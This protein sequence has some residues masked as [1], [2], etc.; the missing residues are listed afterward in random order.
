MQPPVVAPV[1]MEK[2]TLTVVPEN[3]EVLHGRKVLVRRRIL[4]PEEQAAK[5]ASEGI[6]SAPAS[7]T[8]QAA[9]AETA[10]AAAPAPEQA[11]SQSAAAPSANEP[12]TSAD[13]AQQIMFG[14]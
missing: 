6:A 10:Q 5:N 4:T 13:D 12:E 8:S 2:E 11:G 14:R 1:M 7:E 9:P 3:T